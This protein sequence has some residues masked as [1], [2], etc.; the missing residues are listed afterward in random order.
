[1]N[2]PELID[3]AVS[4]GLVKRPPPPPPPSAPRK[5]KK[6]TT[7]TTTASASSSDPPKPIEYKD[8]KLITVV[9]MGLKAAMNLGPENWRRFSSCVESHVTPISRMFR[10]ASLSLFYYMID[11]AERGEAIPD[12]YHQKDTYWKQWLRFRADIGTIPLEGG[13]AAAEDDSDGD[14]SDDGDDD[15]SDGDDDAP[16]PPPVV[17][18]GPGLYLRPFDENR[19][20]SVEIIP[21]G[22]KVTLVMDVPE[23]TRRRCFSFGGIDDHGI[24]ADQV[25]NFAAR[26]FKTA[27]INNAYLTV[28]PTLARLTQSTLQSI[29]KKSRTKSYFADGRVVRSSHVFSRIRSASDPVFDEGDRWDPDLVKYVSEARQ[30]LGMDGTRR[31]YDDYFKPTKTMTFDKPFAFNCWMLDSLNAL[32]KRG[33]KL[34]PIFSV[35]RAHIRMDRKV[36]TAVAFHIFSDSPEDSDKGRLIAS[37]KAAARAIEKGAL[38]NPQKMLPPRPRMKEKKPDK[39][40]VDELK[41]WEALDEQRIKDHD[42]AVAAKKLT[43]EYVEMDRKYEAYRSAQVTLISKLF[44]P[45]ATKGDKW[46]FDGSI[47]TDGFKISIQ[48]S[49]VIRVPKKVKKQ[50]DPR[51]AS[52]TTEADEDVVPDHSYDPELSTLVRHK[53]G[54]KKT[55][56]AADDPGRKDIAAVSFCLSPR[57]RLEFPKAMLTKILKRQEGDPPDFV[58]TRETEKHWHLS[59]SQYR[60][61]SGIVKLDAKKKQRYLG[62]EDTWNEMGRSSSLKTTKTSDVRQ[63]LRLYSEIEE[64]WWALAMSRIEAKDRFQ[65]IIGKRKVLDSFFAKVDRELQEAF[66]KEVDVVFAYGSAGLKMKPSGKGEVS[67]PTTGA[68]KAAK[69]IFKGRCVVQDEF[70]ST[71]M[72]WE[73][74]ERKEAVYRMPSGPGDGNSTLLA[75]GTTGAKQMPKVS[76]EH[77]VQVEAFYTARLEANRDRRRGLIPPGVGR[78]D[79]RRRRKKNDS[80][81]SRY[82]EVRGLRYKPSMRKYCGRDYDSAKCIAR[83]AAYKLIFGTKQ[84]PAPFCRGKIEDK[85]IDEEEPVEEDVDVKIAVDDPM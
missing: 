3:L 22:D 8:L 51:L 61:D 59:G 25:V 49:R 62:L 12:L 63:Y 18:P 67:V 76:E 31:L 69:R 71:V 17:G 13:G 48:R 53:G 5:A 15:D 39:S 29:Q 72:D 81:R 14:D 24:M 26:A 28:V 60:H 11:L 73:T 30:R 80:Y 82:P 79:E 46:T 42:A 41:A 1:M 52:T 66:G 7:T 57:D 50:I 74:A 23:K 21:N 38:I 33:I 68:Y 43:A 77:K 65:R 83:L 47:V 54:K 70:R 19:P 32:G 45:V 85:T 4:L 27:V 56:V 36:L 10:S 44:A 16:P 84:K 35:A 6:S 58:R 55:L 20:L 40:K 9:Q 2:K 34:S 78:L 64:E 75:L 37:L